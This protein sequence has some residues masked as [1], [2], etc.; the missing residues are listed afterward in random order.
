MVTNQIVHPYKDR[1]DKMD[2]KLLVDFFVLGLL[3]IF[4]EAGAKK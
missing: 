3:A 2:K 1:K 4:P